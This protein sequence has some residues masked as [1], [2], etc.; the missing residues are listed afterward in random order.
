MLITNNTITVTKIISIRLREIKNQNKI[1][2]EVI[3]MARNLKKENLKKLSLI[4][5]TNNFKIDLA[6]YIYNPSHNHEYPSLFK[7]TG[8]TETE[9]Q[10]TRVYYFKYYDKTGRYFVET[11]TVLKDNNNGWSITKNH[12]EIELEENSKFSLKH[13]IELTEQITEQTIAA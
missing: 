12:N 10:Y 7:L 4:Q 2:K 13:L 1:K 11:Y 3:A 8:E 9:K 6:N 5:T